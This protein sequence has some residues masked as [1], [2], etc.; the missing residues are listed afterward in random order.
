M[1]VLDVAIIG[2]GKPSIYW[3]LLLLVLE[4]P[5]SHRRTSYAY[6][7]LYVVVLKL[8]R[9]LMILNKPTTSSPMRGHEPPLSPLL[10]CHGGGTTHALGM[11]V[12][13]PRSTFL[14]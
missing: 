12:S 11:P 4:S 9:P 13:H 5:L 3:M 14:F 10:F 1:L 8:A 7:G 2:F 6:E